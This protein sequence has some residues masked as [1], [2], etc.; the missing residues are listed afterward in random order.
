[1][2]TAGMALVAIVAVAIA[3]CALSASAWARPAS[4]PGAS[5]TA[6]TNK[7]PH[8]SKQPTPMTVVDGQSASFTAAATGVPTPTVQWERSTNGGASWTA[9]EGAAATTLTIAP[10]M[11]SENGNL[12]RATFKNVVGE[13]ATRGV[14]LTVQKAPTITKQPLSITV[15]E[16]ENAT[17]EATASGSPTPTIKWETSA[18]AGK[19]W[20]QVSGGTSSQLTLVAPKTTLSGHE[21]RANFRNSLGEVTSQVATLTV[22]MVPTLTHQPTGLSVNEGQSATFEATASGFPTPTV[23]WQVSTDE[24]ATWSEV[25]GATASQLVIAS[26]NRTENGYEYRAVFT[27]SAGSATSQAATLSVH[28]VPVVTQQPLG[29]TVEVGEDATF[30]ATA[31]GFPTPTGQWEISTDEGKTWTPVS[32]AMG[33]Q[34]TIANAQAAENGHQYRDVFTNSVGKTASNAATLTVATSHFSALAWGDNTYLQLG[35]GT[36]G[37]SDVPA[38]VSGLRFV[39]A[40]AAGGRHSLALLA[41]GTVV[42]WGAN[43][44]GQLGD[45]ETTA[46]AVPVAVHGLSGVRAIAAGGSHSLALLNNGTVMAW[47][48]NEAGQLGSGTSVEDSL[49]PVAVQGLSGVRAI[50][51]GTSFSLALLTNGT[52]VSWGENES[53]QLGSGSIRST[54]SPVAVKR[55]TNASAI[56]AGAEFALALLANGTVQSWGNNEWGQLGNGEVE[57]GPNTLATPVPGLSGVTSVAAGGTHALALLSDG[58]VDA[59]GAGSSGQLGGGTMQTRQLTPVPVTGLSDVAAISAGAQDSA[60]LL[61]TGKVMTW[62]SS[63]AGVLGDGMPNGVSDVPVTVAGLSKAASISVGRSHMLAFGEP[64]PTVTSVS[65]ALG[66]AG[67]GT[68][69]T[70]AGDNFEEATSVRFGTAQAASFTVDSPTSITATAP[71]GHGAVDVTVTTPSGTSPPSAADRFT[72][73]LAPT[74]VKLSLKAGPAS[75]GS[76]VTLTGSEFTGATA[77]KFGGVDATEYTVVSATSITAVVSPHIGGTVDVTVSNV[78]GS[79]ALSSKD[80]FRFQPIVEAVTPNTGSISGGASVTVTGQGFA[81]GTTATSFKFGKTKSKSVSCASETMCTVLVP[82]HVAGSVDVTASVNKAASLV[83]SPA[84][85]FTYG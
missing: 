30:E 48:D 69:V 7:A 5:P 34:L 11:F 66:P 42:A 52:L 68:T 22:Q 21:Y 84:D 43:G 72:F 73:Q 46:S 18:N 80:H 6:E 4:S 65:P 51:A 81:V 12:F 36:P 14:A 64:I 53:G 29:V 74:V 57:E 35:T 39:T 75:G 31:T 54:S 76:K 19:T 2:K 28:A 26:A 38:P 17:F 33:A 1:M 37:A 63:S 59:W 50:A 8:V 85:Q 9:I 62:G 45:G 32:G 55:I 82:A 40:V 58:T 60:G 61:S 41:N 70:I 78:G 47:G 23:Q 44:L 67:G 49:V 15:E 27:N 25:A 10:A 77:V 24:G 83:N 71:P 56:S 13:E 3:A 79:S 20:T 16:G